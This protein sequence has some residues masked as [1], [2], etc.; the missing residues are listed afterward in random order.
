MQ[1]RNL[2]SCC[3]EHSLW[4]T[5]AVFVPIKNHKT[6]QPKGVCYFFVNVYAQAI[7]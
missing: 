2:G 6:K 3:A 7:E 4:Q 1:T 5:P